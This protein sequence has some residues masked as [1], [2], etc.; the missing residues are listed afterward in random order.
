MQWQNINACYN[1]LLA[2]VI[3]RAID[4]LKETGPRCPRK[5]ADRAMAFVLSDTCEAYCLELGIDHEAIKEKAAALYREIIA[6]ENAP[7]TERYVNNPG[8][9]SG[10]LP[11]RVSKMGIYSSPQGSPISAANSR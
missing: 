8:R 2:A 3:N 10:N 9:L 11:F 5:E 6:R 1:S 4:D 7:R